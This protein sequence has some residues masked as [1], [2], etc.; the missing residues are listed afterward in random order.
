MPS[1]IGTRIEDVIQ[2]RRSQ[3]PQIEAR[4]NSSRSARQALIDLERTL[5]VLLENPAVSDQLK[6]AISEFRSQSFHTAIATAIQ[7]LEVVRNRLLRETINMGVSGQ[8]RVGKSTLLQSISGLSEE[9]IPTG[10]GIPVTA[11]RSRLR[12]SLTHERGILTLHTFETFREQILAPYHSYIKLTSTPATLAEFR[13]F[14]YEAPQREVDTPLE[15]SQSGLLVRL[16]DIQRALPSYEQ[17]LRGG[18]RVVGLE[19]LRTWVA[20]PT[21]VEEADPNCPRRYLAVRDVQIDC[22]FPENDV[23]QLLVIDLPGL[24]ELDAKAEERHID[25][26]KHDVDLVLL[27]K[28]PLEGSAFWKEEDAKA[29]DLLD[30]ARGAITQRRD[31]VFI[32]VNDGGADPHLVT[33]LIEDIRRRA[34]EGVDGRH[35][36]VIQCDAKDPAK[37]REQLLTPCLVHLAERLQEMDREVIEAAAAG[38]RST[39]E[40]IRRDLEDLDRQVRHHAPPLIGTEDKLY[41]EVE[42]LRRSL[43]V[44]LSEVVLELYQQARNQEEDPDL[45]AGIEQI[46]TR[47]KEWIEDQGLGVGTE[48]WIEQAYSRMMED[49]NVG[50]LAIEEL[51]RVRVYISEA[52]AQLDRYFDEQVERLWIAI[53]QKIRAHTG[54]LLSEVSDGRVALEKFADCLNHA[55]EPCEGMHRAVTDLLK[56][57]ISYRSHFH[58]RV[59]ERIDFLNQELS[60][61]RSGNTQHQVSVELSRAGAT[62]ALKRISD[63]ATKASYEIRKA[64]LEE[65]IVP[66]QALHASAE[67]FEDSLIRSE[68]SKWEFAKL[69]RSYRDEIWP[70]VFQTLDAENAKIV[71][72]R[73][74]IAQLEEALAQGK[75]ESRE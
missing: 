48:T 42:S 24:G 71:S 8:A 69:A 65:S 21:Q 16:R 31:F 3:L 74:A 63:L 35:Y 10:A 6:A 55:N 68:E 51:N 39:V 52:Y 60:D 70:G 5:D 11:V 38:W 45:I 2:L 75:G 72:V 64:L 67:Q 28:R 29:A 47:I 13:E 20:Y 62:D 1:Q 61:P 22:R 32:V 23:E 33:T 9:Q 18:T 59:R 12:H 14:D 43:A 17:E 58:P 30:K 53:S 57:K 36:H 25:G 27:V 66:S 49:K 26:L 7:E 37:V 54:E 4:L 50:G 44:S 19:G 73:R 34:N 46:S 41:R 56:L 15:P 40:R